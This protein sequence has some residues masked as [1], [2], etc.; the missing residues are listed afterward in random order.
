MTRTKVPLIARTAGL[1]QRQGTFAFRRIQE[2][3]LY[4]PVPADSGTI[5]FTFRLR[6][7]QT[8]RRSS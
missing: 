2:R 3:E 7:N 8:H 1:P 5:R 6:L 4:E